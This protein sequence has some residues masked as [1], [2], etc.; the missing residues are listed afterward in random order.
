MDNPSVL[1]VDDSQDYQR[2]VSR[3]LKA[4][5]YRVASA[6]SAEEA[7]RLLALRLPDAAILDWNMPGASGVEL[8]REMR[9]DPRLSRVILLL[10][11]VNARP[12]DQV[13]ALSEGVDFFL[14][15]PVDSDELL[16][17][18]SALLRARDRAK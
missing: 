5:G 14:T 15:K 9:N 4:A 11:T 2:I 1:I 7:R 16:A 8:A 12:E 13:K 10:L 18:L 6:R 17:R 3:I